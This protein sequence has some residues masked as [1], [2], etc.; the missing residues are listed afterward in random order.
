[1][2]ITCISRFMTLSMTRH[3]LNS[4]SREQRYSTTPLLRREFCSTYKI[5]ASPSLSDLLSRWQLKDLVGRLRRKS[6][7]QWQDCPNPSS[8]NAEESQYRWRHYMNTVTQ[9]PFKFSR[10]SSSVLNTMGISNSAMV[11]RNIPSARS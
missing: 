3:L 5:P 1:M 9:Q 4:N 10:R 8:E 11:A 6:L 7:I 2:A